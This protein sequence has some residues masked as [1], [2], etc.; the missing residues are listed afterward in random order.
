MHVG[1]LGRRKNKPQGPAIKREFKAEFPSS[2][3]SGNK[4]DQMHEVT[5]SIP[6]LLQWVKGLA[7]L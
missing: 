7:L 6:G 1:K 4:F 5:G 3:C 2:W